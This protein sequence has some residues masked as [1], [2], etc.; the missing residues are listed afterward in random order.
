MLADMEINPSK[1]LKLVLVHLGKAPAEHLWLN[2]ESLL[3]RFP[4]LEIV[5]ISDRAHSQC[6]ID[7]RVEFYR[8]S[9]SE[10]TKM[11]LANL[12]HDSNFRG[13]FWQFTL[14][15]FF[16]LRDYHRL[17]P[18]IGIF[19]IES[20]ILLLPGFPMEEVSGV[21]CLTWL[22]VDDHRDIASLFFSPSPTETVWLAEKILDLISKRVD[23]T[24]MTALNLVRTHNSERIKIF[25]SYSLLLSSELVG[26]ELIANSLAHD[27]SQGFNEFRGIF[28]PA[29]YGMWLTGSDPRNY[30]GKQIMFDTKE[31]LKG[32]TYIDPS[33][34]QY[35]F[36][37]Q[38]ELFCKFGKNQV[39]IWSLHIHSKDLQ[40]LGNGWIPRLQ[41]LVG[42]SG[43]GRI[44]VE[45]HLI[46]FIKMIKSNFQDKTLV[47]WIL[48]IPKL[49]PLK[50]ILVN[51]RSTIRKVLN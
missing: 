41:S 16:A 44:F 10:S 46:T 22:R 43:E 19:H 23:L 29:A 37:D 20:D 8:Y 13:G 14:E 34:F 25:P 33:N 21:T 11:I 15:R 40:L 2:I 36:S 1:G 28:D 3:K 42:Q 50:T 31:L 48:H 30:Y 51:L 49:R 9:P 24:D 7:S 47:G 4:S 27:L 5:F 18:D 45:F 35:S 26:I 6:P 38:G 39:R 32:G 12:I 17:N